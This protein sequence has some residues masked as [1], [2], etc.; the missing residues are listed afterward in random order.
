MTQIYNIYN[1]I[2][3]IYT[4]MYAALSNNLSLS[5][6]ATLRIFFCNKHLGEAPELSPN[7]LG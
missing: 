5:L 2:I 6:A 1:Y 7:L 3:Y 4:Q